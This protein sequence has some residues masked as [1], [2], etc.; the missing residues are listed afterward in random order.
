MVSDAVIAEA[1][2]KPP[3]R[4]RARLRGEF[5]RRREGRRRDFTV[6]WVHLKL[7]DQTQRTVLF[8]DPFH[9]HDDAR[10]KTHR[11]D[12]DCVALKRLVLMI[13]DEI[14][15]SVAMPSQD[16][17]ASPPRRRRSRHDA[18]SHRPAHIRRH[19]RS[20]KRAV[21]ETIIGLLVA[22]LLALGVPAS[23]SRSTSYRR[24]RWC[25]HFKSAI[26]LSSTSSSSITARSAPARS[27]SSTPRSRRRDATRA[28]VIW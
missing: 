17:P 12:V 4:T 9:A 26:G 20:R 1:M 6:D 25:R 18:K 5:I 11:L 16:A 8:K 3:R 7:N 27:S 22:L 23:R 14:A 13:D 21:A 28:T 15:P 24:L 2:E 10:R 19:A